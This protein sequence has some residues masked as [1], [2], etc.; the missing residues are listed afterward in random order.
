MNF[1]T[2][3]KTFRKKNEFIYGIFP[4]LHQIINFKSFLK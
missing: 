3:K 1:N 4:N 2:E